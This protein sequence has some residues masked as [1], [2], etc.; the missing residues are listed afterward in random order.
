MQLDK[1]CKNP[2]VLHFYWNALYEMTY[3]DLALSFSQS[4]ITMLQKVPT[5][6]EISSLSPVDL[7]LAPSSCKAILEAVEQTKDLLHHVW[8]LIFICEIARPMIDTFPHGI[9]GWRLQYDYHHR[10]AA[11]VHVIMGSNFNR[12]ITVVSRTDS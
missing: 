10:I 7:L 12:L 3:N 9:R 1:K 6:E 11:M 5:A 4:Q 2:R 8:R